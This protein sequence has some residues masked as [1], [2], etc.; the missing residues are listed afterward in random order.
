MVIPGKW[1]DCIIKNL[2]VGERAQRSISFKV[3]CDKK[4]SFFNSLSTQTGY[5]FGKGLYFADMVTKSANYCYA[6]ASSN[7]GLM[8]LSDVALGDM[9]ELYGAKGM[10]KPP[11]GKHSTKG[12]G[13]PPANGHHSYYYEM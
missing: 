3:K 10:S 11:A 9:Y 1:F 12:M 5:M 6:N 4:I 2:N 13:R 8:I 7:I